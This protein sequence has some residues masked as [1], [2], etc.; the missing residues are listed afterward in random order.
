MT[1]DVIQPDLVELTKT[2][3]AVHNDMGPVAAAW[4]EQTVVARWYGYA[5]AAPDVRY[6]LVAASLLV[7]ADDFRD[8]PQMMLGHH[9]I[10]ASRAFARAWSA[11]LTARVTEVP[12]DASGAADGDF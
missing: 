10:R 9:L 11:E 4:F 8:T 1:V 3:S 6:A 5:D 12:D 7:K 2:V